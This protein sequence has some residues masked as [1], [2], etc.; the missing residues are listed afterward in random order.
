MAVAA[1][2][3]TRNF[4]RAAA[5]YDARAGFQHKETLRVLD[6]ALMV[7]PERGIIADIGC[8][9]G[10]FVEIAKA[11]RPEWQIVGIDIAP[12]MCAVAS[13]RC[14][15]MLGDAVD[16]PLADASV[17]AAVSSLCYQW[18][19]DQG[20]AFRELAR[21]M[22]PGARAVV[23]SLGAATLCELREAAEAVKL[24][25]GLL[26]MRDF[27]DV[28]ADIVAAGLLLTLAEQKMTREFYP[29][30]SAL[31]DSMR[32]I[33]AGNNFA[34]KNAAFVGPKRWAA[35]MAE[36]EKIATPQGIPATW[37]HHF[38]ILHKPA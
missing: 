30:V 19:E 32:L 11:K 5:A 8:G 29:N 26:P 16:L 3:L 27:S 23:A 1:A 37:E 2:R 12:G 15:A 9:T 13:T 22:K 28:K 6:A 18:V 31:L 38:F 21:V 33:G 35:M 24:P 34:Q 36:Y 14:E 4:S 7:L 25:L 17:D 10:Y 20:K